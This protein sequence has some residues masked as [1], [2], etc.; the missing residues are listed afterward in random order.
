MTYDR[1]LTASAAVLRDFFFFQ[2]LELCVCVRDNGIAPSRDQI[3]E[4]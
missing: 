3:T 2:L 4:V 1:S